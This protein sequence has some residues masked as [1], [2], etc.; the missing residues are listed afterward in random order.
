MFETAKRM[1]MLP[2][3]G[4]RVMMEK[5]TQMQKKGEDVI[6]MEIGRPDF[7]TPQVIKDAAYDS[8][9]RGNVFYTSN[10]GTP[11]LRKAIAEKQIG[12]AHV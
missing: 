5:A 1:E 6:H 2:F 11:E 4:I 3:S 8:I 12:R 9:R 10:Y 7:D